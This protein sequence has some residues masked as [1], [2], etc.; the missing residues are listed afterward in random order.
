MGVL[1]VQCSEFRGDQR[2]GMVLN[3]EQSAAKAAVKKKY[4]R[5]LKGLKKSLVSCSKS[6]LIKIGKIID[7][8][9]ISDI[10]NC[11]NG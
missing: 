7:G 6:Y 11:F 9:I 3:A 1:G 8:K 5:V 4:I 2:S 10:V